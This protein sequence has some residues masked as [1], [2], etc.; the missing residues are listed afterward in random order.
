MYQRLCAALLAFV[1]A[2]GAV[3]QRSADDTPLP[4]DPKQLIYGHAKAAKAPPTFA[5]SPGPLLF[6]DEYYIDAS[7]NISREVMKPTRDANIPNPIVNGKDDGCFQPYM[8]ILR[9]ADTKRFRLWYGRHTEALES[10]RSHIGYSE[11]ADGVHWDRPMQTLK[12]PG[13]IQF[14]VAVVDAGPA[15]L[16]P[17]HRYIYAWHFEGWLSLAGSPDGTAWTPL[18]P[19]Q[20]I[21]HSHDINGLHYDP[22]R[23]WYVATLSVYR[24][25][26]DWKNNRRVTMQSHSTDLVTWSVPHYV[27]L[28]STEADEGETQFYAMDGYLA[29][30]R[31]T[32][33]MVKVLRDDLKADDPPDPADAYGVGYT[34]LAWSH[35]GVHWLRDTDPKKGAWDHAHAWIDEQVPVDGE[36]YLYYGGYAR[37]HKVNRFEERQIGLLKIKRDRY[38]ARV[39]GDAPGVLRTVAF[40]SN[41]GGLSVNADASKGSLQAQVV[42]ENGNVLK[43]YAYADCAPVSTDAL[44]APLQWKGKSDAL[45]GKTIRLEFALR[46]ARLFA[47]NIGE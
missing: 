15:A 18:D 31:T 2:G 4:Q 21:K 41:G 27:A 9:D 25:G 20:V 22:V 46:N 26:Y 43:G 39:A 12:D 44:D 35:D 6:L 1:F 23:N 24:P 36:V 28:P 13:P 42:D 38:V 37:G 33:G 8:T 34:A 5:P 10:N 14:G 32:V 3:A 17:A 29:R 45:K 47:L 11:S 16:S 40:T 7:E 19:S 30:G